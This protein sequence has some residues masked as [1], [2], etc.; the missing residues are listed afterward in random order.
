MLL[1]ATNNTY[2]NR[3]YEQEEYFI[4]T[5][6]EILRQDYVSA[7][8]LRILIKGLGINKSVKYIKMIQEE[9]KSKNYFIPETKEKLALTKLVRKKFGI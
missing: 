4:K 3:L 8:D 2:C 7:K 9:M 6:D 1:K 5:R